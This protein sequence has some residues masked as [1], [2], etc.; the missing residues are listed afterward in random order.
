MAINF[1]NI[2]GKLAGLGFYSFVL[3]WLLIF[4]V[5]LGVLNISGVFGTQKR[6]NAIVAAVVAFFVTAFT[7]IGV[8][9][10]G[11]FTTIFGVGAMA[12]AVLL[13]VVILG[14]VLGYKIKGDYDSMPYVK[15]LIGIVVLVIAAAAF[16]AAT[17]T[18]MGINLPGLDSDTWAV[19]FIL[20]FVLLAIWYAE[21]GEK[22][23]EKGA[24]AGGHH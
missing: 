22:A 10:A 15:P 19:I 5:V 11:Y 18:T 21:S 17:G 1:T 8:S 23:P 4:A 2:V 6:I 14:G 3:P 20:I 9:L 13:L 12:I 7:P 24:E 16:S